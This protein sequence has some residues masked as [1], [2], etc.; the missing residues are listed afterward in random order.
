MFYNIYIM[1]VT[2]GKAISIPLIKMKQTGRE[3]QLYN[4]IWQSCVKNL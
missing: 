1:L 4:K 2:D 3:S